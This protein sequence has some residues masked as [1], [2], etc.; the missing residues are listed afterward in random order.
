MSKLLEKELSDLQK[1]VD[2]MALSV[3]QG[4]DA[5]VAALFDTDVDMARVVC[6][7]DLSINDQRFA[8][9]NAT[10]GVIAMH[11]PVA[12]DV[13]LLAGIFEIAIEL[14]RMGD[15]AKSIAEVTIRHAGQGP[16]NPPDGLRQMASLACDMLEQA[17]RSLSDQDTELAKSVASDDTKVDV[18]C[19]Q[20]HRELL[21]RAYA[22]ETE[23]EVA[24][25]F[26]TVVHDIE[27]FA[28]RATNICERVVYIVTGEQVE[29]SGSRPA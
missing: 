17:I 12:R 23:L 19:W 6:S 11:Q 8:L 26:L 7:G 1:Q 27:R 5:S 15:Y 22:D 13:R 9:E 16:L 24:V 20:L 21:Q 25:R 3:R 29:F 4:L 14:E 18:L 2:S 28:D 10:I